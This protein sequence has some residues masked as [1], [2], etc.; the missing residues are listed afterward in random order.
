MASDVVS[1]WRLSPRLFTTVLAAVTRALPR[2]RLTPE[3]ARLL[4]GYRGLPKMLDKDALQTVF[5]QTTRALAVERPTIVSEQC[6]GCGECRKVCEVP[7]VLDL[8]I[9]GRAEDVNVD[10]GPDCTRCGLCV[11]VCP[12]NS[13]QYQIKGLGEL[14]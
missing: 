3:C 5:V 10:I 1:I 2:E 8:T 4:D 11:D 6:T 7:H 14:L 13:L 9:K 12:T